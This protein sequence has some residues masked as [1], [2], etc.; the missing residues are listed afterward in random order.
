MTEVDPDRSTIPL[1]AYCF[2][3]GWMSVSLSLCH[4]PVTIAD[5]V[6]SHSDVVSFSAVFVWCAFQTGN[7]L[8]VRL[9]SLPSVSKRSDLSPVAGDRSRSPLPGSSRPPRHLLPSRRQASTHLIDDLPFRC[10]SWSHRRPNWC[11]DAFMAF[12]WHNS[13]IALDDGRRDR[14]MANTSG[15]RFFQ[16]CRAVMDEGGHICVFGA[17]KCEHGFARHHGQAFEHAVCD[18]QCVR[19]SSSE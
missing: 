17:D 7:T 12:P 14:P 1:A 8:Q 4:N 6:P 10:L 18:N 13:S 16:S 15:Q 2:M 11:K 9:S 3:T 19:C 5:T